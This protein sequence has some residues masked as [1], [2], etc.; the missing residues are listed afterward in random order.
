MDTQIMPYF[1][2][3]AGLVLGPIR[4]CCT[5][6]WTNS[7]MLHWCLDQFDYASLVLGP[8]RLYCTGA[9]TNSI[10]LHLGIRSARYVL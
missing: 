2:F 8:I 1:A 5:G 4:L 7:I 9:W 10:M 3:A 6:A